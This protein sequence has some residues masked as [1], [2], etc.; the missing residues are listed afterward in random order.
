M[1]HDGA[2]RQ[3]RAGCTLHSRDVWMLATSCMQFRSLRQTAHTESD[4][5]KR[6]VQHGPQPR[7]ISGHTGD[8]LRPYLRL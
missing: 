6:R 5:C 8:E 2:L 4:G 7:E 3:L 1:V